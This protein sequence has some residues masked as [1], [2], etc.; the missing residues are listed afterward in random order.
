MGRLR[1]CGAIVIT[2][3]CRSGFRFQCECGIGRKGQPG[4]RSGATQPVR[5]GNCERVHLSE[6]ELDV[7]FVWR[8]QSGRNHLRDNGSELVAGF[9]YGVDRRCVRQRDSYALPLRGGLHLWGWLRCLHLGWLQQRGRG[10][11]L[12]F[13][14]KRKLLNHVHA[15]FCTFQLYHWLGFRWHPG[16][17]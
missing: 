13:D 14:G 10:R 2:G 11:N 7:G 3:D 8:Q 17:P 15:I 12:R 5:I 16:D 6:R 9:D 4:E 1:F